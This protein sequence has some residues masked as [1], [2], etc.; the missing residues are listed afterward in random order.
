MTAMLAE[1]AQGLTQGVTIALVLSA[2]LFTVGLIGF[3]VQMRRPAETKPA[4]EHS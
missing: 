1:S 2:A 3:L 4:M